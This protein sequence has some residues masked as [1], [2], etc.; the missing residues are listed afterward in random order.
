MSDA[1]PG[2]GVG[3]VVSD[4]RRTVQ[5]QLSLLPG[6]LDAQDRAILT[7]ARDHHLQGRVGAQVQ[8]QLGMTQ[9]RY[10]Q[11]LLRLLD[12][13]EVAEPNRSSSLGWWRCATVAADGW[14]GHGPLGG[15][16]RAEQG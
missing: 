4:Q 3:G 10:Y 7:F 2:F 8:A 6:C 11:L 12:R 13:V 14:P 16:A 9:T 1:R 15:Q 5:G